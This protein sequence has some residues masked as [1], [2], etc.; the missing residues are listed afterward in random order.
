MIPPPPPQHLIAAT[1]PEPAATT[2]TLSLWAND[3]DGPK[4]AARHTY[5]ERWWLPH[6]GPTSLLLLR[7][8]ALRVDARGTYT[9]EVEDLAQMLGVSTRTGTETV[10]A[11]SFD[12]LCRFRVA[13]ETGD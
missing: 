10:L 9:T 6:L 5:V 7:H 2:L 1:L 13:R 3:D 12:R 8:L 11:R 4:F